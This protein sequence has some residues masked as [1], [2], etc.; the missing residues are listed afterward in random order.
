MGLY[1]N[2]GYDGF[3]EIRRD[4]YV[5]KTGLI[6]F[7]NSLIGKPKPLVCFSRPR[8]FGKTFAADMLC[9]Y[10][11]KT[12]DSRFLFEDLKVAAS[13]DFDT[14]I[15][16]FNV[17]SFDMTGFISDSRDR[18]TNVLEEMQGALLKEVREEFPGCVD[19]KEK[20]LGKALY[21]VVSARNSKFVFVIDE[22]DALFREFKR[23]RQLQE[24]YI[25]FLRGLFKNKDRT[26]KIIAA[27]YM[28]GI[29]PVKKYGTESA[30]SDFKEYTMTAPELLEEYVGFTE[31][32][33]KKLCQTYDADFDEMNTWYD[34]YS[35]KNVRHVYNPNSVME[36]LHN[37]N[38]RNYWSQTGTFESLK[39]Y[40]GMNYDGLKDAIVKMLGGEPVRMK[41][42]TFQNDITSFKTADDVLT[43]LIHFGYLAYNQENRTVSI[44]NLEVAEV[45]EDAV[46]GNYWGPVGEAIADSEDLLDATI[47]QNE[48]AVADALEKIHSSVTSVLE[49][50]NE[51]SLSCAITIAYYTA[52]RFYSIVRE[53]PAGRGFAD[54]AFMPRKD[55]DKP[56]MI[57]ELKYDKSADTAIRQ[58]HENRYDGEMK[59]YFGHLLL[60][61]INYRKEATGKDAKKHNCVIEWA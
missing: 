57:V 51:A 2:P 10:Y 34:G 31:D 30:L 29:L 35:F 41:I 47:S 38:I 20:S 44:P 60:V 19:E 53:L 6:A 59:D 50:N 49:Y 17:I 13:D 11:D 26:K 37:K 5:D 1:L 15:N 48:E 4:I 45:F 7:M 43:L 55:V 25:L 32:E 46:N 36:A 24:D 3:E 58:I 16:K 40:I 12:C 39:E 27:A 14:Y 33:V 18:G 42:S 21:D 8:R 9:A 54:L 56:A 28:T 52:K 23:D 61:G 22:W